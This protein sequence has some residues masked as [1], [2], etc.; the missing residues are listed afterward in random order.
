MARISLDELQRLKADVS[1]QVAQQT[2]AALSAARGASC[3]TSK[4]LQIGAG[5]VGQRM[6]LQTGP[7]IFDR[8]ELRRVGRQIL[9]MRCATTGAPDASALARRPILAHMPRP[10]R[11]R[12]RERLRRELHQRG[13]VQ[14]LVLLRAAFFGPLPRGINDGLGRVGCFHQRRIQRHSA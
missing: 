9:H 2:L 13:T 4:P 11:I 7:Q 5:I 8:V 1:K 10:V 6:G 3:A 14:R 12:G